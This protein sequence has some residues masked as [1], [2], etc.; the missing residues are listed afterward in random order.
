MNDKFDTPAMGMPHMREMLEALDF[1]HVKG[2][3]SAVS[4]AQIVR[5]VGVKLGR[6]RNNNFVPAV[7]TNLIEAAMNAGFIGEHG[8]R[9]EHNQRLYLTDKGRRAIGVKRPLWMEVSA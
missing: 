9:V 5:K 6:E 4:R 3:Y 2:R 1:M 8:H 7:W